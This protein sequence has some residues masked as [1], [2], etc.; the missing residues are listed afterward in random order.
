MPLNADRLFINPERPQKHILSARLVG[1]SCRQLGEVAFSSDGVDVELRPMLDQFLVW[2]AA[3]KRIAAADPSYHSP[4][5]ST[6]VQVGVKRVPFFGEPW[7]DDCLSD[8]ASA[9]VFDLRFG[10]QVLPPIGVLTHQA[11]IGFGQD[12]R[13]MTPSTT[14]TS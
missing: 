13:P 1:G 12:F 14:A 8:D 3:F 5:Q 6:R 4:E 10:S 2:G 11:L 7:D 9:V